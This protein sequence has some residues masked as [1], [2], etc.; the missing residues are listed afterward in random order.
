MNLSLVRAAGWFAPIV[1]TILTLNTT[2]L[3]AVELSHSL[4]SWVQNSKPQ[5]KKK[6]IVFFEEERPSNLSGFTRSEAMQLTRQM[7]FSAMQSN[8]NGAQVP[9]RQAE[10]LWSTHAAIVEADKKQIRR[11]QK[12]PKV[13]EIIEDEV[14]TLDRPMKATATK[15]RFTEDEWTY[16]LQMIRVP[17]ARELG[18]DGEGVVVGIIDS[19]VD[20]T[21]P[22]LEGKVILAKDFTETGTLN[23]QNGHGTHVAGTIAGGNAKGIHIG[24]APQVKIISAKV[25]GERGSTS[26]SILMR[27]MEWMMDPDGDPN[28]DDAPRVVNNS[29][30][31]SSQFTIGF[32]HV[33]RQWRRFQI[34]PSFA[35]GNSGRWMSVGAPARYPSSFAVAAVDPEIRLTSFSSRGP[36]LWIKGTPDNWNELSWWERWMPVLKTKP[37]IAAPGL[38]VYSSLPGGSYAKYSGTSMATP[39]VTGAIALL[40]QANPNLSI[41]QIESLL[42][43]SAMDRGEPKKDNSFGHGLIQID[44]A[45]ELARE[46][47][48]ELASGFVDIQEEF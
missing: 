39:H 26:L 14:I 5:Q 20:E 35:A 46:T 23:D 15:N 3:G 24:V 12:H 25:F 34:F 21:H 44:E 28:T 29:W 42:I 17:E 22:E 9:L 41:Q 31:S 40:L 19:G 7:A 27:A 43:R 2:S 30:G 1:L 18:F 4:E 8:L 11:L 6:V 10:L 33:V 32:R 47:R 13:L 37:D 16:G 48:G 45:L 36:S 38:N